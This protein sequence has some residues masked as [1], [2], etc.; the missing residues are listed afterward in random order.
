MEIENVIFLQFQ[1]FLFVSVILTLNFS[2]I[3]LY[4]TL[5]RSCSF[6]ILIYYVSKQSNFVS[7]IMKLKFDNLKYWI[8]RNKL[9]YKI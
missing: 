8:I 2:L 9:F 4:V 3:E 6:L 7:F 1:A 5:D